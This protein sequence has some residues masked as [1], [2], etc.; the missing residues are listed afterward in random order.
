MSCEENVRSE[1]PDQLY[2]EKK[3]ER[4]D[5]TKFRRPLPAMGKTVNKRLDQRLKRTQDSEVASGVTQCG[6]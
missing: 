2:K 1:R 3:E 6:C 4:K 5:T